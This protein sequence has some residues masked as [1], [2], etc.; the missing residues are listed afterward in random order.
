V[1]GQVHDPH[2]AATEHRL[3]PI[4]GELRSR[5]EVHGPTLGDGVP[6][7]KEGARTLDP[8]RERAFDGSRTIRE[9]HHD[10]GE[11]GTGAD[12]PRT[13]ADLL[14]EVSSGDRGALRSGI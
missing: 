9:V 1:L 10:R 12:E 14:R 11:M 6:E 13:D 5:H 7:R 3:D 4:P 2:P 8:G